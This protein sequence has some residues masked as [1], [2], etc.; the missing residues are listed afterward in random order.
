MASFYFEPMYKQIFFDF[1]STVVAAET[2]DLLADLAGV[3]LHVRRLTEASMNGELSIEEVFEK[4]L[5]MIS[6]SLEMIQTLHARPLLVN[7]M[8]ELVETLHKLKK[9]VFI[10]TSNFSLIVAPYATKL[11]I[12]PERV[13]ANELFHDDQGNY[14]GMDGTSALA[15]TGGK[16]IMIDRFIRNKQEAVMIGDS[17]TDLACQPSVDRFIGFGGVIARDAVRAKADVFVEEADARALL[18]H[19]L[20]NEELQ[21]LLTCVPSRVNA[22]PAHVPTGWHTSTRS[23][24][25][26]PDGSPLSRA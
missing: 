11:G 13:I 6:P 19:L 20:T 4:K 1:D 15:H 10:L 24:D 3:G 2:L 7:G 5:D 25:E 9:D 12:H 17:V 16:R 23:K 22:S 18:A 26:L 8:V 14:I 21:Q